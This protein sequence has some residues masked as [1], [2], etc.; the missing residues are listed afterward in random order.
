MRVQ[1]L[2]V[3]RNGDRVAGRGM[4]RSFVGGTQAES[5]QR[6]PTTAAVSVG[7]A[8]S[9]DALTVS[10]SGATSARPIDV[11]A[12]PVIASQSTKLYAE[13]CRLFPGGVNSP[14]RAWRNVGGT[15][16]F[17]VRAEGATVTDADGSV[18]CDLVG[19]WGAAIAGHAH[20]SVVA[21]VQAAAAG[22]LGYG[23]PCP[24]EVALGRAIAE[25][26][27]AVARMRMVSSGTEAVMS[28]VRVA[29][30]F[31]GRPRILK[32]AGCYHGHSDGLLVRAGS[33]AATFGVPDSAGVPEAIAS[34]TL[35]A[36]YNAVDE[37]RA[38]L[39]AHGPELAAVIVEPV[40][41]NMGVVPPEPGFLEALREMTEACGA[42]LVFDEVITGFRLGRGG[43]QELLGVCPDLTCLG[44]IIGGGL[45]V[46]AFGG[47][48]D[49]MEALA[50]AGPV[51]QAGTLSGNPVTMAAGRAT[52]DLLDA[53]AYE[54]LEVLGARAEAG[55]A[56]ALRESGVAGCVQ[57]AGSMLTL[58]FGVEPPRNLSD[59]ERVDRERFARFF[60]AMLERGFYLP[61][62][63]FEA[64][65]LSLAHTDADVDALL[66]AAGEALRARP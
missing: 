56:A 45:P 35:V 54:R 24:A 19:S 48:A 23:A 13:A 43:A 28:A 62:S 36:S 6:A 31:T 20:P 60:F 18:Y 42:L 1:T 25:S 37:V 38:C 33:G 29:R 9:S 27:P 57:R 51:Y 3:G 12:A 52:L 15:P 26:M 63:P 47:R 44:K 21:A 11:R 34:Q 32:L 50:P 59:V 55:L 46:G 58:F 40:A 8:R 5:S 4:S 41:A 65:F 7:G 49:V 17:I 66:A 39:A 14:V 16:R 22:G 2:R 64:W 30:A 53:A 61:P 10:R